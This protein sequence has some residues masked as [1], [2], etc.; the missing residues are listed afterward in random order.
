[1][2][3]RNGNY[4]AFYVAEPFSTSNLGAHAT[5][6]FCYYN[7]LKMWKGGD[8]SFP[9][10]DSH[11]KTYSV[12]DSSDWEKTLKPRLHERLKASK[13]VVLFLSSNTKASRALNEEVR[14]AI[15]LGLPIIVVYP[16]FENRSDLVEGK[17][18]KSQVTAL[19]NNLPMFRDNMHKVATLHI[20]MKK[21]DVRVALSDTSFTIQSTRPARQY[22]YNP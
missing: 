19:W 16:D 14:Y 12:R 21:E 9:F 18:F 2:N 7:S 10:N 3:Y 13:N 6:D 5:K 17:K 11:A 15:E 22:F 8:S 20:P 1:M 4:A